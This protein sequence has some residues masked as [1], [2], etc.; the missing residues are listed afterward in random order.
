MYNIKIDTL[1]FTYM[2]HVNLNLYSQYIYEQIKCNF[3][4]QSH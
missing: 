3:K 4:L 2:A 1:K